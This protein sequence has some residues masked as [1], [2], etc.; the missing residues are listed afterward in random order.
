MN[1]NFV[2]TGVRFEV[3]LLSQWACC[4][5]WK[6]ENAESDFELLLLL[7]MFRTFLPSASLALYLQLD[8]SNLLLP[9]FFSEVTS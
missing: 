8:M 7:F 9:F 4:T 5:G 1:F 6:C 2:N 3:P